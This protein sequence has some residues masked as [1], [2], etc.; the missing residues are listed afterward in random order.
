MNMNA[1]T[2]E[3]NYDPTKVDS[4]LDELL[5]CFMHR[6]DDGCITYYLR[7]GSIDAG[8]GCLETKRQYLAY[9][10]SDGNAILDDVYSWALIGDYGPVDA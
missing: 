6:G 2:G 9:D 8:H 10:G 4:V 7:Y 5:I 1:V 3:W